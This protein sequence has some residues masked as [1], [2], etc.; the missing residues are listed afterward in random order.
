MVLEVC[1]WTNGGQA[2]VAPERPSVILSDRWYNLF[3]LVTACTRCV[4]KEIAEAPALLG[5]DFDGRRCADP[6][7]RFARK[8]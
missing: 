5:I 7:C 2:C 6:E 8:G 3:S 1:S 4:A